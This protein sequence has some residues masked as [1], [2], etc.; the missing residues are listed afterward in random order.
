M[1]ERELRRVEVLSEVTSGW[2]SAASAAT[3]LGL[4]P[5]QVYRLL[6]RYRDRG[7]SGL[8]ETLGTRAAPSR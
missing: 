2:R 1:S 8:T 4:S 6:R 3:A 7:A 5:R